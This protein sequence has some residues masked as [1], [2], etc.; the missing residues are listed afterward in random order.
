MSAEAFY[1]QAHCVSTP[2]VCGIY[3]NHRLHP[4][5]SDWT[6]HSTLDRGGAWPIFAQTDC[7]L[8][9]A[10]FGSLWDMLESS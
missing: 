1:T 2:A 3:L 7:T 9:E 4:L 6:T 8:F 5:V 10:I